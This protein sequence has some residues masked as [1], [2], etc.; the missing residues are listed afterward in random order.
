MCNF[1]LCSW[2]WNVNILVILLK[3]LYKEKSFDTF[4]ADIW[5]YGV[6]LNIL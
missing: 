1:S 4:S 6:K 3:G 2:Q 5:L